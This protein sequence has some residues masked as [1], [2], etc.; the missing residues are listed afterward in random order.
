MLTF[1]EALG[2]LLTWLCPLPLSGTGSGLV[3]QLQITVKDPGLLSVKLR[4]IDSIVD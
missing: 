4:Q 3:F 1:Q 2:G